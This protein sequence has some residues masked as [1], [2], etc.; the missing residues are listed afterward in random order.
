[1][2]KELMDFRQE[3][4]KVMPGYKWTVKKYLIGDTVAEAEGIQTSGFNRLCTLQVT[5][6]TSR[7]TGEQVYSV[8]DAGN[9]KRAYWG[10]SFKSH[11]LKSALRILQDYH[12]NSA[13]HHRGQA[14]YLQAGR[15]A[16]EK[17]QVAQKSD[18][19]SI[20]HITENDKS[21]CG[22]DY[23]FAYFKP[24]PGHKLCKTCLKIYR[25]KR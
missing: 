10:E 3:L 2:K 21:L 11:S 24:V 1:M 12:E 20:I 4:V 19:T 7:D 14:S 6:R 16:E 15:V 5:K 18:N 23:F 13:R 8:K 22:K 25:G 17:V 9:G